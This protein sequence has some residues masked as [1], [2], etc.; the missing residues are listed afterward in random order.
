MRG[1]LAAAAA[2]VLGLGQLC[3]AARPASPPAPALAES[4]SRVDVTYRCAAAA[5]LHGAG[6]MRKRSERGALTGDGG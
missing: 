4:G 1:C 2:L 3:L 6:G 5:R